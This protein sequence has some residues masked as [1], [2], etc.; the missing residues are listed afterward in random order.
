MIKKILFLL[1]PI[2]IGTVA[3]TSCKSTSTTTSSSSDST[4]ST[5]KTTSTEKTKNVAGS[6]P[7]QQDQL[8]KA[9]K[10]QIQHA[11]E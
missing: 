3:L 11:V 9:N 2:G 8:K 4:K 1:I 7:I 6:T 5:E 10:I